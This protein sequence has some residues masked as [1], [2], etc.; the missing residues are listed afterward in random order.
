MYHQLKP[1][2]FSFIY[3]DRKW[4]FIVVTK[5]KLAQSEHKTYKIQKYNDFAKIRDMLKIVRT[6]KSSVEGA[7]IICF[8]D[9]C[10]EKLFK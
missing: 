8:Y 1:K 3:L 4:V 2:I 10:C 6:D 9:V 5:R 7:K